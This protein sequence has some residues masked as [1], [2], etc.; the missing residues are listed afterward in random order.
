MGV[1]KNGSDCGGYSWR[2]SLLGSCPLAT[3]KIIPSC[4][5]T[6]LD[7]W[8][9]PCRHCRGNSFSRVAFPTTPTMDANVGSG[10][11]KFVVICWRSYSFVD[12]STDA[13]E[14]H[15]F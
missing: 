3:R 9:P 6:G 5:S 2:I 4:E 12:V 14:G 8:D 7:Q 11:V 15:D 13:N 10:H 1:A